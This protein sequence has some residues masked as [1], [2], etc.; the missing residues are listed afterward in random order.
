MAT[1]ASSKRA[2]R[3]HEK[4]RVRSEAEKRGLRTAILRAASEEFLEYGYEGFSLRRVAERI[5]Y[6]A[7]T[8]YLYFHDKDDLLRETARGG[9][10]AFDTTIEEAAAQHSDPRERLRSLGQA[11][12]EFGVANPAVYRLMFMQRSDF[13]IPRLLGTSSTPETRAEALLDPNGAPHRVVAQDQLVAAI[14]D[15]IEAGIFLEGDA[16]T[17]ADALWA[18][19]HGLTAL[20]IGPLMSSERA[21]AVAD[22]LLDTLIRGLEP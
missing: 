14:S 10:M 20:A 13:L 19:I 1:T 3:T 12:F 9:F 18:S 8:I 11:Y 17:K 16:F 7:T 22:E 4:S 15:G 6:T 2:F 21:R 5:D